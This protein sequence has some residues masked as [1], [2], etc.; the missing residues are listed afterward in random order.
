MFFLYETMNGG[1]MLQ[2]WKMAQVSPMFKNGASYK[3]GNDEP[4][5]L[6]SIVCKLMKSFTWESIHMR[7]EDLF[8]AKTYY[9]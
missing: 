2:D 8:S 3:A 9:F 1:C 7:A 6:T 4:I 5:S